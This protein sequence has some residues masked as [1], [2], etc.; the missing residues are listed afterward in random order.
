MTTT[1]CELRHIPEEY[2]ELIR[3]DAEL[4]LATKG[5]VAAV[6]EDLDLG[7]CT[8]GVYDDG[9]ARHEQAG[10]SAPFA[11]MALLRAEQAI[12]DSHWNHPPPDPCRNCGASPCKAATE[13]TD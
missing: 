13:A 8:I 2:N 10:C 6:R 9:L 3:R 5:L 11:H 7:G 4:Y 12:D 1:I